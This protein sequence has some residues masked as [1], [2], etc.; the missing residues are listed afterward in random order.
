MLH[1]EDMSWGQRVVC[2]QANIAYASKAKVFHHHGLHQ[3]QKNKSFRASGVRQ[4]LDYDL[5]IEYPLWFKPRNYRVAAIIYGSYRVET[6][7]S[8]IIKELHGLDIYCFTE[9]NEKQIPGVN[10]MQRSRVPKSVDFG[11]F[12]N[13]CTEEILDMAG[14]VHEIFVL[15]NTEYVKKNYLALRKN[16]ENVCQKGF[17]GSFIAVQEN[18]QMISW[19]AE[20]E[21]NTF[22]KE[23]CSTLAKLCFGQFGVITC[24]IP[25]KYRQ[26]RSGIFLKF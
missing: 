24:D 21:I 19:N 22:G 6:E 14:S 1:V 15:V 5:S 9:M 10:F 2:E 8:K 20:G 16:L 4:H 13:D 3:H 12:L 18:H 17:D 25:E 23:N 26:L 7:F 11:S